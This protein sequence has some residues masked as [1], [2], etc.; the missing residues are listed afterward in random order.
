MEFIATL[1]IYVDFKSKS[2]NAVMIYGNFF[3]PHLK[4][5]YILV[6]LLFTAYWN[7]NLKSNLMTIRQSAS[8]GNIYLQCW[9]VTY[10]SSTRLKSSS[11][12]GHQLPCLKSPSV[13]SHLWG[14]EDVFPTCSQVNLNHDQ[15]EQPPALLRELGWTDFGP[16]IYVLFTWVI[17]KVTL[18][19]R[20]Q[21]ADQPHPH[22]FVW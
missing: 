22:A 14:N 16:K 3:I 8:H 18:Q 4:L 1:A 12:Q 2:D 19:S 11:A 15:G 7:W 17:I 9:G 10:F 21:P 5:Q 20:E 6:L 13:P